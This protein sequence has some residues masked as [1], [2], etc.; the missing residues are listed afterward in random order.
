[1][2]TRSNR[3]DW[4][5]PARIEEHKDKLA[6]KHVAIL[7]AFAGGISYATM[8]EDKSLN[9]GTVKSRLNRARIALRSLVIHPNG[10]PKFSPNGAMLDENGNR[11]IF[12]DVDQ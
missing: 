8:A 4:I 11:S 6:A 1:M 7:T 5:T 2:A 3:F 10:Q 12:D 9:I